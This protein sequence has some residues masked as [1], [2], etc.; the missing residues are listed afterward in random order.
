MTSAQDIAPARVAE[1]IVTSGDFHASNDALNHPPE[2]RRRLGENSYLFFRGLLA[3]AKLV[4]VRRDI[5]KLCEEHGWL[6][7]D[8]P[9]LEGVYS[10]SP[11]PEYATEYM[12]LYR[13][14]IR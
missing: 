13:K 3:G 7:T 11:F 1:R 9:V 6:K 4:R 14:L 8:T 12:A 10:G 2:L 5:L